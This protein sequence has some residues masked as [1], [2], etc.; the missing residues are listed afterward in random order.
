[1]RSYT[2]LEDG[3]RRRI[4][5]G[6]VRMRRIG[7]VGER[8]EGVRAGRV[9]A[10]SELGR[11]F[12]TVGSVADRGIEADDVWAEALALSMCG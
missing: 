2:H 12:E 3:G 7:G 5:L 10:H 11:R 6:S 9:R 8:R 4:K 1:M